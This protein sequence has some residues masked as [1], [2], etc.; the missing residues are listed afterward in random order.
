[1]NQ[2]SNDLLLVHKLQIQAKNALTF[3]YVSFRS[4]R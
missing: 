1:M 2:R 4:F 3:R